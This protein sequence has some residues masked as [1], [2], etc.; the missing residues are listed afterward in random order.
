MRPEKDTLYIAWS[1]IFNDPHN[2]YNKEVFTQTL[3]G[4]GA[5]KVWFDNAYGWS[6]QPEVVLF[7][8]L[9]AKEAGVALDQLPV[10]NKYGAIIGNAFY[11]WD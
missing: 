9:S 3:K 10:F 7:T 1:S 4:A 5:K 2:I 11:N 8:G 6:N